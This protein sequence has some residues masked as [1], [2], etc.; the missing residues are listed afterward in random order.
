MKDRTVD[1]WDCSWS[2]S[3]R[4]DHSGFNGC[5]TA[6]WK[7]NGKITT[8]QLFLDTAWVTTLAGAVQWFRF[9]FILGQ[10]IRISF[11][12][13]RQVFSFSSHSVN[14]IFTGQIWWLSRLCQRWRVSLAT[15]SY[16]VRGPDRA[17]TALPVSPSTQ[18]YGQ[19]TEI[20]HVRF[21]PSFTVL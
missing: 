11:N 14:S 8:L 13:L 1:G 21:P 6:M 10:W 16:S 19:Y 9:K 18:M 20:R 15:V 5:C 3:S 4:R 12:Q 2:H 17:T 7:A